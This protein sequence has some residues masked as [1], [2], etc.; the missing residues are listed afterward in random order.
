[1]PRVKNLSS[2]A[3]DIYG[4]DEY[5]HIATSASQGRQEFLVYNQVASN[6]DLLPIYPVHDHQFSIPFDQSQAQK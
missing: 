2:T 4:E 1:M 5:R 6:L 3:G